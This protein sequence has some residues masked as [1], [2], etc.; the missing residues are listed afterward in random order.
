MQPALTA[1]I[2]TPAQPAAPAP[3]APLQDIRVEPFNLSNF[4]SRN[5]RRRRRNDDPRQMLLW[6]TED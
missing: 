5:R 2:M 6:K 1:Y 4:T 3:L